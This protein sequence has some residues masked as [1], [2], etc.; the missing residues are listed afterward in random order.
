VVG[1]HEIN[2]RQLL[3]LR[4]R[5]ERQRSHGAAKQCLAQIAGENSHFGY[6]LP[7]KSS[8]I[9][10]CGMPLAHNITKRKLYRSVSFACL[11]Q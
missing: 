3:R 7:W 4:Y 8:T 11:F 1:R 6:F 9:R 10:S 2:V 5:T